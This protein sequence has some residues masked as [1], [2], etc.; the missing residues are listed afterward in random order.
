MAL[1]NQQR[2]ERALSQ[3]YAQSNLKAR[4]RWA[5]RQRRRQQRRANRYRRSS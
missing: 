3:R 4:R 2:R 5:A 1:S